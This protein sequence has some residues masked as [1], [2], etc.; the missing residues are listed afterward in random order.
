MRRLLAVVAVLVV[1]LVGCVVFGR[2]GGPSRAD[3]IAAAEKYD[4]RI[5]RDSWGVPHIFGKTDADAAFGLAYA[6]AEDDMPTVIASL[7][8]SRGTL[9]SV[10]GKEAAPGDYMVHLLRV[11]P[12][13]DEK[14]ESDLSPEIRAICEAYADGLN[15]YAALHP[16]EVNGKLLPFTG[17]DVVAGFVFKGPFFF[18]VDNTIMDLFGD[19]RRHPVSEKNEATHAMSVLTEDLPI[20]SNTFAVS[21]KRSADGSTFLNINS[22]QPW[23]GP[24]A[25]YEAHMH[26]EEGMDIVGGVFPGVPIILHGHNRNLGWAH[27]VNKPDLVDVYVLEMNP[28]NPNQYKFD[29]EWRDLEVG[30]APIKVKLWGPFSWTFKRE[31]LWS[32]HGPVVRQDHGVYAIR[33]AGMGDVRTVEQ[34]YRMGKAQNLDEWMDAMRMHA[35]PSFNCGYADREG[36]I[37]YVYNAK[38]PKRAEGYNWQQYLPGDTSETLWTEFLP[39]DAVP[40]VINPESGFVL[41]CNSTPYGT[42]S[43]PENPNPDAFSPTLG[44]ETHMTNRGLRAMELLSADESITEDEFYEY[45]YDMAYSTESEIAKGWQKVLDAEAPDDPVLREAL[46]VWHTWDLRTNPENTAAAIC[47]L[48]IG[49]GSDNDPRVTNLEETFALLKRNAEALKAAHG[50]INVPWSEVNRVHRGDVNVGVGGG[51]DIL[52]AVYGFRVRNGELEGLDENG[53]VYGRAGDCLVL[54]ATW[55]QDGN[56]HSRSIHQYGSATSRPDSPHYADQV[57]LFVKRETKPV[58]MDEEEIRAN[59]EREYRPGEQ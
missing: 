27:T 37:A 3:Y 5:L 43:G 30:K 46:D 49:P 1:A 51:P 38:F 7:M 20:G 42:T 2:T 36:N 52:H 22:H 50:R 40:M 44:I 15:L 53:E 11:W 25:W 57:P 48:T 34:W 39:F 56:L 21:P 31:T 41:N 33:Y 29:G 14:Y 23:D 35:I 6:Q 54:I 10:Q 16:D 32:V 13:V 59:L 58:W 55:D 19:E 28:D 18:G 47:V 45:K 17:K 4:V 24:V 8:Q 9:A 26:S 12:T